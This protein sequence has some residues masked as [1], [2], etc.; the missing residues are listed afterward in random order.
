MKTHRIIGL[1]FA[2]IVALTLLVGTAPRASASTRYTITLLKLEC[3]EKQD[4]WANG[5]DEPTLEVNAMPVYEGSGF[6][7][8][9]LRDF[10]DRST[11]VY[12]DFGLSI[13][14]RDEWPDRDDYVGD[15][16]IESADVVGEGT[17]S[18]VIGNNNGK[19]RVYY[20]VDY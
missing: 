10:S 13:W 9:T 12:D 19:Y 4:S 1:V 16:D 14:E 11:Y 20:R 7:D 3:I 2:S 15:V 17:K 8:G 5:D 6:E 18:V